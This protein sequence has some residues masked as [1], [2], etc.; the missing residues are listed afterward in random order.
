MIMKKILAINSGSSSL[1]FKLFSMPAEVVLI[2]GQVERIGFAD[3]IFAY[4]KPKATKHKIALPIESHRQAIKILLNVLIE[5]GTIQ[6]Y[7][8]IDGIGHRVTHG[9]RYYDDAV[10]IDRKV[11]RNIEKLSELSPLHNPVNLL[12][13]QIF[14]KLV[15]DIVQVASFDTSFHQTIAEKNYLYAIPYEY[16]HKYAIRRYGFHGLS[17]QYVAQEAQ[18]MNPE[19]QKM[20]ICHIGNGVS[21][22]AIEG[23]HSV[24]TSMGFTPLEGLPMGTRS[25]DLDPE[26]VSFIQKKENISSDALKNILNKKSGLLGLSGI[27]SDHRDIELAASKG[28]L[29]ANLALEVFTQKIIQYIGAYT[30]LLNGIDTLVFTAG[31]GEH[32]AE[33]R[34]DVC[35]SL[36]YLGIEIDEARNAENAR[37]ISTP[38]S[39]VNVLVIP[40]NEEVM[41]ARDTVRVGNLDD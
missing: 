30:A 41:I 31:I 37:V 23:G 1:K 8:D 6:A 19:A 24:M 14:A 34:R 29:R 36:S 9:G 22:T 2:E 5:T 16:Y 35:R 40:T 39:R 28:S 20:V 3:A 38:A 17:H 11:R 32:S 12:A 21:A 33:L 4:K 25:G 10:V 15:P 7:T 27:S 26:I 13:I 18:K